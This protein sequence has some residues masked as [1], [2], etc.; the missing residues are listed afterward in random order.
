MSISVYLAVKGEEFVNYPQNL[1]VQIGFGFHAD[2]TVRVPK[3]PKGI[4]L[5]DDIHLP[6]VSI[7]AI[8]I[9]K[10]KFQTCI[11]DFERTPDPIHKKLIQGMSGKKIIALPARF[12]PLVSQVLPIVSCLE[13]CNS[14]AQFAE[15]NQK[16][17]PRGW[18]LEI[19]PWYHEKIGT[20]Q[21]DEGFLPNALCNFRKKKDKVIYFDTKETLTE[22]LKVA[23][24]YGC[25]A[26][27][28]LYCEVKRL[29]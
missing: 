19:T 4:A 27:I 15:Q 22:K 16:L 26:A 7:S 1:L 28:A 13:P 2:G 17:Y 8:Q 25:K 6:N 21:K 5:I 23:E 3:R 14:W 29:K 9:L 24:K 18:M 11:F 12:H 10:S 20:I